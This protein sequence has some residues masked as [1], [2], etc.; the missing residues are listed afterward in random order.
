MPIVETVGPNSVIHEIE[1]LI[2]LEENSSRNIPN[3]ALK[4]P[5]RCYVLIMAIIL[6]Y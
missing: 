3:Y 6:A 2:I 1:K 5:A 4:I